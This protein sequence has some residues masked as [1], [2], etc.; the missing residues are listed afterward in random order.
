MEC[1]FDDAVIET[2]KLLAHPAVC[3]CHLCTRDALSG[4]YRGHAP[5]GAGTR[6]Y[7]VR[8]WNKPLPV[9]IQ[10]FEVP[11]G[12]SSHECG[13]RVQRKGSRL[14]YGWPNKMFYHSIR[15]LYHPLLPFRANQKLMFY[16]C[17]TCVITSNTSNALIR[18]TKREP[19]LVRG[20]LKKFGWPCG[21][22]IG[23]WRFMRF[24]NMS[25]DTTL[26]PRKVA[27]LQAT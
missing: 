11:R 14:A 10:L 5:S 1:E 27:C 24:M 26:N 12:Q 21:R 4:S 18:Q 25:P 23:F 20:S 8:G 2:P 17:G 6:D 13:R 19:C 15:G 7:P 16:L 9:Y 3:H 22:G